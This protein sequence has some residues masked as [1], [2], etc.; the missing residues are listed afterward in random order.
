MRST[1]PHH[2]DVKFS[3]GSGF[4][5]AEVRRED[6]EDHRVKNY[7]SLDSAALCEYLCVSLRLKDFITIKESININNIRMYQMA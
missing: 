1:I 5:N 4:K 2:F 7:I 6:A 3:E